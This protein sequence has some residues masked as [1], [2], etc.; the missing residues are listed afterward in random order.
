MKKL[1]YICKMK[2]EQLIEQIEKDIENKITIHEK[3]LK[4]ERNEK[5]KQ[6]LKGCIAG[7][8]NSLL[9]IPLK[10]TLRSNI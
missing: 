9:S 10:E 3:R 2:I 1:L 8:R 7:L 6:F 4:I 5:N